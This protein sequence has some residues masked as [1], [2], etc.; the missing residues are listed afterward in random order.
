MPTNDCQYCGVEFKTKVRK[1][2]ACSPRC[3]N[4]LLEKETGY[5]SQ[6]RKKHA[7]SVLKQCEICGKEFEAKNPRYK[8]CSRECAKLKRTKQFRHLRL[9]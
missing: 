7:F 6:Y 9:K 8:N 4:K 1:S 2:K 3:R 5:F